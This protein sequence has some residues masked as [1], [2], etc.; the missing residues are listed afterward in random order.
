MVMAPVYVFSISVLNIVPVTVI[1][2]DECGDIAP[3]EGET[4]SHAPPADL[5]D[6]RQYRVPVPELV[7]VI[8]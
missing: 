2:L 7:I 3:V 1:R 4:V 6:A 5:V 8:V